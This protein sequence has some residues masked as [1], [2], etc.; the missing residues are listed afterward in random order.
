MAVS[1]S[2]WRSCSSFE[3]LVLKISWKRTMSS[4]Q[5]LVFLAPHQTK[6]LRRS[7]NREDVGSTWE[8]ST[9]SKL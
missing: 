5:R 4:S 1:S 8:V 3:E 9:F 2:L 7:A 6:R